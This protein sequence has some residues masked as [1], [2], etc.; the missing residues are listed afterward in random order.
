MADNIEVRKSK[1]ITDKDEINRFISL[2]EEDISTSFIMET[3][4]DFDGDNTYNPYDIITIPVGGYGGKLPDG[5]EKRNKNEFNTTIGR[6]LLSKSLL[7]TYS[8]FKM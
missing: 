8:S 5:T 1:V 6:L 2:K 7:C 4:G 3:F